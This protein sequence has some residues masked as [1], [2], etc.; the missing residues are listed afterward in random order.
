MLYQAFQNQMDLTEPLRSL[1]ASA[2][3]LLNIASGG[4]PKSGTRRVAAALELVTR[5]KLTYRR[6]SYGIDR[7]LVGNRELAVIEEAAYTTPFGTLLRFKRVGAPAQPKVLL[8]AP[9]SG[10]FATLLRNTVKTMAQDHDVYITDW[11]NP[12]DIPLSEGTFGL[13]DYTEHLI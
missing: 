6:P 5:S 13:A 4:T 9:M 7:V 1:A 3:S 2:L 11:H 10:H 8:V 12:R